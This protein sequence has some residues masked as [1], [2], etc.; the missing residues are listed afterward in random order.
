M[1]ESQE[2]PWKLQEADL[3]ASFRMISPVKRKNWK[4]LFKLKGILLASTGVFLAAIW[5]ALQAYMLDVDGDIAFKPD[6]L[7]KLSPSRLTILPSPV[8]YNTLGIP[9]QNQNQN[10]H[11][12]QAEPDMIPAPF[13][14]TLPIPPVELS[15]PAAIVP[16]PPPIQFQLIGIAEGTEGTVA[17]LKVQNQASGVKDLMQD[18]RE[19]SPVLE[20][21]TVYKITSEYVVLKEKT[22]GKTIRVE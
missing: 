8:R 21:Y 16:T 17:T 20:Q 4:R 19:G 14:P 12:N 11:Q 6:A 5:I 7:P 22:T 15:I 13:L 1:F 18:V 3:P 10:Q 2:A 9:V